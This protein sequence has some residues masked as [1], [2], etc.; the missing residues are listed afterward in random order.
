LLI[1]SAGA[2]P[3]LVLLPLI[4]ASSLDLSPITPSK[5]VNSLRVCC[6]LPSSAA[7]EVTLNAESRA[8]LICYSGKSR[9]LSNPC[10]SCVL[11]D[12]GGISLG[13]RGNESS[14]NGCK[15]D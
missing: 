2:S 5:A 10:S 9:G 13:N 15:W 11:Y 6:I 12:G 14:G 3:S 7:G 4:G 1:L 8:R